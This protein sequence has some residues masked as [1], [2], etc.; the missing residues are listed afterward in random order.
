MKWVNTETVKQGKL[1][2]EASLDHVT[3][4]W[5]KTLSVLKQN[6]PPNTPFYKHMLLFQIKLAVEEVLTTLRRRETLQNSKVSKS[7]AT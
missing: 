4:V 6:Q 5:C 2:C 3:L 7:V 1:A